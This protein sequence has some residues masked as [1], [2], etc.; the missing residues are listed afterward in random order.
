MKPSDFT[1]V[2]RI[3][4]LKGLV[5]DGMI[6]PGTDGSISLGISPAG[7]HGAQYDVVPSGKIIHTAGWNSPLGFISWN[8]NVPRPGNFEFIVNSSAAAGTSEI[9]IEVGDMITKG[10]IPATASWEEYRNVTIGKV[11][12]KQAGPVTVKFHSNDP[13]TWKALNLAS[14]TLKPVK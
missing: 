5:W 7:R 8:I 2:F 14:V 12:I 4:G 10:N 6:Y 1:A 9:A 11:L 3:T 13:K